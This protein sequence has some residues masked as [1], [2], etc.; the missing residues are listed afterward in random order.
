MQCNAG[1]A[2]DLLVVVVSCSVVVV[3]LVVVVAVP[4]VVALLVVAAVEGL[5]LYRSSCRN[6]AKGVSSVVKG[7]AFT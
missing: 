5:V 7:S 6:F 2:A 4:V 1:V 3:A